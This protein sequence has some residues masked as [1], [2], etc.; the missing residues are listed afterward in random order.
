MKL[1]PEFDHNIN[2][3]LILTTFQR[4]IRIYSKSIY[5]TIRDRSGRS[6]H[7]MCSELPLQESKK[8]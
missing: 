8:M 7:P 5:M 1:E 3:I 6:G 2:N 4:L